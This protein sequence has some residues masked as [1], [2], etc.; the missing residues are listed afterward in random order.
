VLNL[1]AVLPL[2]THRVTVVGD[3]VRVEVAAEAVR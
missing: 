1:P 2:Q 3:Q